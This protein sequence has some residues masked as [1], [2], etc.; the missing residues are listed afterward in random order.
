MGA[1]L[2]NAG[3]GPDRQS[4]AKVTLILQQGNCW[5][6][7]PN[8]YKPPVASQPWIPFGLPLCSGSSRRHNAERCSARA[9]RVAESRV[10]HDGQ[11]ST[12]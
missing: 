4:L 12:R 10:D 6:L 1:C 8:K 2:E 3:T 7:K 5:H 11:R 9:R